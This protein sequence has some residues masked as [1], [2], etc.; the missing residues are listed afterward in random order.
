MCG[1]V[2]RTM[3][4]SAGS[5]SL[6]LLED[7]DAAFT[8]QRTASTKEQKLTFS[9]PDPDPGLVLTLAPN[10]TPCPGADPEPHPD[11]P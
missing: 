5:S 4:N 9:G 2:L 11:Q 8:K 7:I 6:L 1:Q 3:L 10:P